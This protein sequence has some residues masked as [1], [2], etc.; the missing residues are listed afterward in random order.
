MLATLY[1]PLTKYAIADPGATKS[2]FPTLENYGSCPTTTKRARLPNKRQI[3]SSK[4]TKFRIG[5]MPK[6]QDAQVYK[7]YRH[8]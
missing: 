6:T 3:S 7:K 8:L 2:S 1:S 5:K 4:K